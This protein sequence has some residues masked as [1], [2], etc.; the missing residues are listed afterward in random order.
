M[1][2]PS[3]PSLRTIFFSPSDLPSKLDDP[4]SMPS[5]SHRDQLQ[6]CFIADGHRVAVVAGIGALS[7]KKCVDLATQATNAGA[8]ALM[9]V[10]PFYDPINIAQPRELMADTASASHLPIM[11]YNIP[12]RQ[13]DRAL[14]VRNRHPR[15]RRRPPPQSTAQATRPIW[16]NSSSGFQTASQRLTARTP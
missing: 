8:A 5:L 11:Y 15:R 6:A 12:I 16:R 2:V 14:A 1:I 10:P 9:V 13:R 4:L 3:G 7:T